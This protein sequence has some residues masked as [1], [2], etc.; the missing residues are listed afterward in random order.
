[1]KVN[2]FNIMNLLQLIYYGIKFV[3][4]IK[5]INRWVRLRGVDDVTRNTLVGRGQYYS[6]N[7]PY[8][9]QVNCDIHNTNGACT[10]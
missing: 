1:M 4:V 5:N 10:K 7:T 2:I 8:I 9:V 6:T 3:I